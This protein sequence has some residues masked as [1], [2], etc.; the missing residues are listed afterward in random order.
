MDAARWQQVK[1]VL[2][3]ALEL[4]PAER[5]VYLDQNYARDASLRADVE[6]LVAEDQR[7]D[8]GFLDASELASAA[9]RV[10]PAD[11]IY[12]VGRRVGP[13]KVVEQ[14]GAGGMGEVYRA[15]RADDH[16]RK[17]VALKFVRAGQHS[18]D[19][20]S[21]FKIERQILASLDH[22]N[23]ARLLDGG[24]TEEGMPYLVMEL[25]EGQPITEYCNTRE[26]SVAERLKLFL[27]VCAAVHY[28][29]Q[30]LIIHRD[31]K[32]SNVLVTSD[33]TPKLL[34]FGIAK[35]LESEPQLSL[36]ETTLTNFRILTPSYASPEQIK[37][38]P[39]TTASDVYS[40]GVV[41]YELLTEVS[42]YAPVNGS[43]HDIAQAVCEREPQKPSAVL[44]RPQT[45]LRKQLGGDLDNIVLMSLRKEP[46]RRYASV[47]DL[48]EDIRRHLGNIPVRARNDT[49]WYRAA[50]FV[51]RH[52]AGVPAAT[53]VAL[54]L[55]AG[56]IVNM[57]EA[58]I[59][60]RRFDDVR[61]LANAL[62]FDVHD[63]VKD[64]PG[65]TPARKIIVDRALQYLNVLAQQSAG[66]VGLQRE[67]ATAYERVGSVQ[68]DYL[69]SNL[70]DSVGTLASYKKALELR[71]QI[72]AASKDWNDRLAL[73]QGY[74]LVAHQLWANGDPRGARDPINRAIAVSEAIN[75]EQ[76]NNLKI[77]QE[78]AFDYEVS[79][80]IGYPEERLANQKIIEDYKRALAVDEIAL[81]IKA[82]DVHSM[83]GYAMDLSDIANI[84]EASDPKEALKNYEKSLEINVRL[85]QLS[86]DVRYQ[87]TV[88]IAYGSMASVYDDMGDYLRA[89]E[90]NM[91]DLA[92]YQELVRADSKNALLQQ[93]LAITY[94]NT[95]SSCA[96]AGKIALAMDYS[97][98]GLEIMRPLVSSAS[99]NAFQQG[100]FAAML[101]VRG[102][103][104]T[105]ANQPDAAITEIEQGRSIYEAQFK[106]GSANQVNVAAAD[107]KL[108]EAAGKAGHN[109]KAENYFHQSVTIVDALISTEPA[110]LDALY[111]AADAYSG[112]GELS[113]KSAQQTGLPAERRKS[114]CADA[115]SWYLKSLNT[116]R[117]IE[118][119][120]HTSPN[121][122]QVGDPTVVARKLKQA[123]SALASFH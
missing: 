85:T 59:A 33:G 72:N 42:P 84:V 74:R 61:A 19:I 109:Q 112:L 16:Y 24:A 28:A 30:H 55:M 29:H 121:S 23:L 76:P 92:I 83:H 87:R 118:H 103:V 108:G 63:S 5:R 110:D 104:L 106:A 71:Q 12:W 115:R 40:L 77:V 35:I 96:R 9:A 37:G 105:A 70:G 45:V 17:E 65:S 73:A 67:L 21:R 90:Y 111:A 66:D 88:A 102:T 117:R 95:G 94:M 46:S 4:E 119:P 97:S 68:G 48:Q 91:K 114:Y 54:V 10:L 122:F 15:I 101:V 120:N 50:K 62:I 25:I 27:Q 3:S 93:G 38:D 20:F 64:L 79:G 75:K 1:Q 53:A 7:V 22:P 52:K 60:K 26:L 43:P 81:R 6:P 34:D 82:D 44:Q 69:E 14:I 80:R 57:R 11:E 116:W 8:D 99:K 107:V 100:I 113:M 49:V 86:T 41:L 98:R 2:A 58:R 47:N 51:A 78:L 31:I 89:V 36:P 123:E 18:S 32:P 56:I 39:M 13:Y